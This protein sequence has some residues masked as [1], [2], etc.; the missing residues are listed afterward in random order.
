MVS[1]KSPIIDLLNSSQMKLS[2][3]H[4]Y[5]RLLLIFCFFT[6]ST[7][8]YA[9]NFTFTSGS[10]NLTVDVLIVNECDGSGDGSVQFTVTSSLGSEDA[11]LQSFVNS[12][13]FTEVAT[14]VPLPFNTPVTI[15]G[16]APFDGLSA[17]DYDFLIL[18]PTS[19]GISN[20]A[21][22]EN[23]GVI[24]ITKVT[25]TNNSSCVAVDGQVEASITDGSLGHSG[26]V[27]SFEYTWSSD[28]GLAGLPLGPVTWDGTGTLD[29]ATLLA[30][31]GLPGGTYTFDVTDNFSTCIAN[32]MTPLYNDL[33][34]QIR[35]DF[36]A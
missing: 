11:T 31:A 27:G 28:N 6:L 26:G 24:N 17:D 36:H 8:G 29:L 35:D 20:T 4:N 13:D 1:F 33:L 10:G 3:L 9:Q 25:E 15:L 12:P 2:S 32:T 5:L 19:G 18:S 34:Q 7:I 22:V 21:T 23:L 14:N 16:S 30:T